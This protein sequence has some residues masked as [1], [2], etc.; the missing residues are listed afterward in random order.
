MIDAVTR[1]QEG[2]LG[3]DGSA[4]QE[5][6]SEEGLLDFPQY[7]RPVEFRGMRVPD[8]LRTGDHERIAAWR[9][10]RAVERTRVRRRDLWQTRWQNQGAARDRTEH[11]D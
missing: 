5:S 1:L 9:R 2:V 7:T 11:A 8:V 6:F 10:L 3:H 4:E